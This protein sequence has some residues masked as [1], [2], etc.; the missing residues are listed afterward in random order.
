MAMFA[1]N[2]RFGSSGRGIDVGRAACQRFCRW[3]SRAELI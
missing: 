1:A 2:D 3:C